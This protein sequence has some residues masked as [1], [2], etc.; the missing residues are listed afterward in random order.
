MVEL[1]PFPT[2][3]AIWENDT[4]KNGKEMFDE[5]GNKI[6]IFRMKLGSMSFRLFQKDS[7]DPKAPIFDVCF[8]VPAM[9]HNWQ[10][11]E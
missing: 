1:K 9:S 11:K 6:T 3:G 7:T 10:K 8:D 4:D 2:C 5:D